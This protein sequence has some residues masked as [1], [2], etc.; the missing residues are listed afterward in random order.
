MTRKSLQNLSAVPKQKL[1]GG[2]DW[3]KAEEERRKS[4]R[5]RLLD[6][7]DR[8]RPGHRE[9]MRA[10]HTNPSEHWLV[11]EAE[12]RRLAQQAGQSR[13]ST[14]QTRQPM[15]APVTPT[16]TYSYNDSPANDPV[17]PEQYAAQHTTPVH[18][19]PPAHAPPPTHVMEHT[20][21]P[22]AAPRPAR[23]IPDSIKQTLIERVSAPRGQAP[24]ESDYANLPGP[25]HSPSQ[26]VPG[27]GDRDYSQPAE[28][29]PHPASQSPYHR[30]PEQHRSPEHHHSPP[31]QRPHYNQR[32]YDSYD[33]GQQGYDQRVPDQYNN[34]RQ[35]SY[36]RLPTQ[37]S[38]YGHRTQPE[39]D[40]RRADSYDRVPQDHYDH[41]GQN[42]AAYTSPQSGPA[43]PPRAPV[44]SSSSRAEQEMVSGHQWCSHCEQ[45]L[46]Q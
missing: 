4:D 29:S 6:S 1:M 28:Y 46:G 42:P 43:K 38:A 7:D 10:T 16:P 3:L 14:L 41:R 30:S 35:D 19:S 5:Q 39:Y 31:E 25:H 44:D 45:K 9:A 21:Q 40:H 8:W 36:D 2:T 22:A 37:D 13:P 12:R 17:V 34:R 20:P 33:H 24:P 18:A 32:G 26:Y 27:Y 15:P 23:P 11:E